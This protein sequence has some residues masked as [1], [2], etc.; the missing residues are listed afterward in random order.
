MPLKGNVNYVSIFMVK[1]MIF[2]TQTT[3]KIKEIFKGAQ[4][5]LI[6][7]CLDGTMGE[8]YTDEEEKSA[9][10]VIGDFCFLAGEPNRKLAE[11]AARDYVIM[12]P[13][14]ET[15]CELIVEILGKKAHKFTRYATKKELTFDIK[16]LEC[17]KLPDGFEMKFIDK[18]IFE[19]C[20]NTYWCS[21]FVSQYENFESKHAE[22]FSSSN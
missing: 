4:D 21:D 16:S 17:A 1:F 11:N 22:D 6:W 14:N 5:T 3:D 20:K 15:W 13:Q 2:K 12:V 10:A 18:E 7:S 8:F 19:Y 9:S